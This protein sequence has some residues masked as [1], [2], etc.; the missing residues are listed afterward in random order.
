MANLTAEA[1]VADVLVRRLGVGGVVAGY[2]F[3]FGKMRGGTPA[4]LVEAGAR[5][6]FAVEIVAK[7][8]A[9]EEGTIATAS[10][11]AT[12]AALV[13]GDVARAGKLLGHPFSISG[14]VVAGARLGR[15]LGFPTANIRP[16][17]SCRLRHGIYAVRAEIDG[18]TH[19]GVASYGRRP[20]V[21]N[22]APLLEVFLFDFDGD[23]YGKAMDVAFIA[24][25]R[26]EEKFDGLEALKT[27]MQR[28]ETRARAVLATA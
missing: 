1:F 12:R 14:D 5:L 20:T 10:S 23:L 16:D 6:G 17:A 26:P 18:V 19:A 8:E 13:D 28:D 21:D 22:G 7:I 25:L 24:W 11:T 15:T 3:H 9:D 2:D 27:Q 4:T